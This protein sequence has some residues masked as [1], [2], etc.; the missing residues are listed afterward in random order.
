MNDAR[1]ERQRNDP[2]SADEGLR[3]SPAKPNELDASDEAQKAEDITRAGEGRTKPPDRRPH[4]TKRQDL[5][6]EDAR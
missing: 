1:H 6:Q 5:M 3:R 2:D 4:A